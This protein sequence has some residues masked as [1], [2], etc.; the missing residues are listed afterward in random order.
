VRV[1]VELWAPLVDLASG[2]RRLRESEHDSKSKMRSGQ[3]QTPRQT[4]FVPH[5]SRR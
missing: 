2:W 5:L 3:W 4:P 1:D